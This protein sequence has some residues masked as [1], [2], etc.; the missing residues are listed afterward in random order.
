MWEKPKS[1]AGDC[2]IALR[3]TSALGF[4]VSQQEYSVRLQKKQDPQAIPDSPR[5]PPRPNLCT[6]L[7][8]RTAL[9]REGCVFSLPF[10]KPNEGI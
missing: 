1:P 10:A 2:P 3:A 4:V 7:Y 8:R 9:F 5:C 6:G